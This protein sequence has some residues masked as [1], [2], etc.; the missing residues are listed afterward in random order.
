MKK[1]HKLRI[2]V[3]LSFL[4]FAGSVVAVAQDST[5]SEPSIN[6][7][8]FADNNTVQ[9]LSVQT[10]L[11]VGRKF[12]PIPR[13][14]VQLYIDTTSTENLL[15]KITTNE[16]GE[17]VVFMPPAMKDKWSNGAAHAFTAVM[18]GASADEPVTATVNITKA[19]IELDTSNVDGTRSVNVKVVY[20]DGTNWI[21]AKDVEMKVGVSRSGSILTAG[22]AATYTTDSSGTVSVEFMRLALPGDMKG[23]IMLAAKVEDNEQYGNLLVELKTPWGVP[24]VH[25]GNFFD[26]RTLWSTRYRTPFWLLFMAYSILIGVWGTIVYLIFQIIKIKKLGRATEIK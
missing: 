24:T 2:G 7:R 18:D 4:L 17:A 9:Y 23:N 8:Y 10:R 21:P 14:V 6:L 20:F 22:D 12:Q 13:K 3:V 5:V 25:S 19:K 15:A 11:K 26:Q 16:K 1:L